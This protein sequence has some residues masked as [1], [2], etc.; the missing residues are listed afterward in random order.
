MGEYAR[1]MGDSMNDAIWALNSRNDAAGS[2]V[3]HIKD[4]A[5]VILTGAG[6]AFSFESSERWQQQKLSMALRK[7]VF[8]IF[9]ESLYNIVQHAQASKVEICLKDNKEGLWMT[10]SDNGKGLSDTAD[11]QGNGLRN[12]RKRAEES[13]LLLEFAR[14]ESGGLTVRLGIP[15]LRDA[16]HTN[17]S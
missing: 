16:S 8:L 1:S 4:F 5:A 12:M 6:I 14:S 9:K 10:I 15:L 11:P 17:P 3:K 7:N 2:L 13:G